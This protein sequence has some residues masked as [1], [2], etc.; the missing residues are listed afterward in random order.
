MMFFDFLNA[1]NTNLI[2]S[3][4]M[5]KGTS[6]AKKAAGQNIPGEISTHEYA[7]KTKRQ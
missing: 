5:I 2:H 4:S 7:I 6:K 3:K 1:K